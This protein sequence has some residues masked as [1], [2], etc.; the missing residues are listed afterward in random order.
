MKLGKLTT[1]RSALLRGCRVLALRMLLHLAVHMFRDASHIFRHVMHARGMQVLHSLFEV[2]QLFRA[3]ACCLH[4]RMLGVFFALGSI[5]HPQFMHLSTQFFR[6]FAQ[7]SRLL[8]SASVFG[9]AGFLHEL[10][11]SVLRVARR[12]LGGNQAASSGK[13]S[14][15]E[16]GWFH[17]R[18]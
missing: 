10:L 16:D 11:E 9:V 2:L 6:L 13:D 17:S 1:K 5:L 4:R 7:F 15:D 12:L 3:R 8:E 18:V 14:E